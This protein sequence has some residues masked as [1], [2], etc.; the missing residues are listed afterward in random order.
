MAVFIDQNSSSN[1]PKI[2]QYFV[3][4]LYFNKADSFQSKR[5]EKDIPC[6]HKSKDS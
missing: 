5:M 3:C 2:S 6:E 1:I 4:K